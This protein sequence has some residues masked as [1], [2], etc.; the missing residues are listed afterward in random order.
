M[1]T[2]HHRPMMLTGHNRIKN[3][4]SWIR[5]NGILMVKRRRSSE[6]NVKVHR[7]KGRHDECSPRRVLI[8]RSF[9]WES[10]VYS[11]NPDVCSITQT[12]APSPRTRV[13]AVIRSVKR[14]LE[15]SPLSD[16]WR[17]SSC[18]HG[19]LHPP[20]KISRE[21]LMKSPKS[22]R[23]GESEGYPKCTE[24]IWHTQKEVSDAV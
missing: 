9:T 5:D 2:H 8:R 15:R 21:E 16:V 12:F 13:A 14:A 4:A 24:T 1:A 6:R 11:I 19:Q 22:R 3:R 18:R 17:T 7:H 23:S 20:R 10:G